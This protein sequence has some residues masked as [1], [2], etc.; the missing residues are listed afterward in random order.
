MNL[1]GHSSLPAGSPAQARTASDPVARAVFSARPHPLTPAPA[2]RTPIL[3]FGVPR[4]GTTLLRTLLNGHPHIACGPEAPWLGNHTPHNVMALYD[5]LTAGEFAFSPNFRVPP[6]RV[7]ARVRE[8]VDGLFTDFA[9]RQGKTRWAHKTPDDCLFAPFF[10]RLF[11]DA[12]FLHLVRHPLDVAASTTHLPPHRRGVS[13]WHEQNLVLEPGCAVPN[14]PFNAVL[15]W[16][17]WNDRLSAEL[18]GFACHRLVYGDL[19][20]RPREVMAAVCAFLEEPFSPAMLQYSSANPILPRW[21]WG[22]AD[23]RQA[24]GITTS[25]LGRWKSEFTADEIRLL[26]SLS[27]P[28]GDPSNPAA[29][30]PAAELT[31]GAQNADPAAAGL[32]EGLNGFARTFG[33]HE[34]RGPAET[35]AAAWLWFG[36]L[37]SLDWPRTRILHW[38]AGLSPWPWLLAALGARVTLVDSDP[39]WIPAWQ[40]LRDRLRA[41]VDWQIAP[42][43][44]LPLPDA[45]FDAATCFSLAERGSDP[46][47]AVAE[48]LR[49][50]KPGAPLFAATAIG[51][52]GD[53][54]AAADPRRR[55]LPPAAFGQALAQPSAA[56]GG[57][58]P[59]WNTAGGIAGPPHPMAGAAV[60]I[61]RR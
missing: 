32:M 55:A 16:R 44:T 50:L 8:L 7:L 39:Q 9:D 1:P 53:R 23:V 17:R 60:L 34:A 43:E 2:K 4:S 18:A 28:F 59:P 58:R 25:R 52:T 33:L 3:I 10:T 45:G 21:E 26:F 42:A 51:E 12:R 11:P 37:S 61:K 56:A 46:G 30:A 6:E 14:T 35:G 5:S 41:A 31:D 29:F 47:R 13:P 40:S 38:G 57:L 54:P 20:R 19:V 48:L 22:S 15:R 36:G 27:G 24:D 49:V